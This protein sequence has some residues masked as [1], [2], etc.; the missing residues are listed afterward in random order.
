MVRKAREIDPTGDYRVIDDDELSEFRPGGYDLVLS[1]FTFD[2]VPGFETKVWLFRDLRALLNS[3]GKLINVVSSPEIYTHEWASFSTK[4]F[5]ENRSARPGDTVRIIT[6]DFADRRPIED[7]L[8]TDE[9]YWKVYTSAGLQLLATYMPLGRS[10]EPYS[11]VNET[12][13]APWIIYVLDRQAT[14][15]S[16]EQVDWALCHSR[17]G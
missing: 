1:V 8:W 4:D 13:I 9:W 15:D 7:I 17:D 3:T 11:W 12:T 16:I 5:P 10:N 2:N 14:L 6:T